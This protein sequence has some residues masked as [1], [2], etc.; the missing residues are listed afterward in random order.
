[1]VFDVVYYIFP[2]E[3]TGLETSRKSTWVRPIIDGED[4][5]AID[6][7][8]STHFIDCSFFSLLFRHILFGTNRS[9]CSAQIF[10]STITFSCTYTFISFRT[11]KTFFY[12]SLIDFFQ[13]SMGVLFGINTSDNL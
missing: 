5:T 4:H 8:H 10:G 2:P 6:G 7:L 1:M 3:A 9:Q 13:I 12:P 11:N